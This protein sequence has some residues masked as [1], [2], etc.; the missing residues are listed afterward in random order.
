MSP[1]K[2]LILALDQGTTT[3]RALIFDTRAQILATGQNAFNQYYPQPGWVEHDAL[4]ILSSQLAAI[5]EALVVENIDPAQIR[6]IGITNQRETT[7]LWDRAT[8]VPVAPAIVWQCRRTAKMIE[9][10]TSDP[11]VY[12]RIRMSTGLV[13]DAYFSA[14]KIKWLLDTLPGVRKRA[15]RGELA[16]GTIDSWLIW[17]LTGGAVHATDYTNASRTM[18]FNIHKGCWDEWLLRLFDVP[19]QILPEVRPSAALYGYTAHPSIPAGIPL[20]G[21]AGDQQAALFGQACFLPGEAKN[22]YGTGCFMLVHTGTV[23][24]L[25]TNQLLTTMAASAPGAPAA[26]DT[27]APGAPVALD[28]A[29]SGALRSTPL[30]YA[31]EGSVFVSG[32]LIQWLRDE[33]GLIDTAAQTQLLAQSVADTA[34][35]HIVPAFTGLG[36]PYW[37]MDARGAILGLTRGATKAHI[38]RAALEAMA[39]QLSDLVEAVQADT[40]LSL[41]SLKVD[42][43][44]A[45]NDFLLQFQSDMLGLDIVRPQSSETTALGAA[46]LAGLTA[47]V[48]RSK[49]EL[50]AL[51]ASKEHRTFSPQMSPEQQQ[52]HLDG[53]HKAIARVLS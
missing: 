22:T 16:F 53:W 40:A 7:V 38:V 11:V 17:Q 51:V 18:L 3:S 5:T 47:G 9:E 10:L 35:V 32:A 52:V 43:G 1:S 6:C 41:K 12:E 21:V 14:S 25:S 24:P 28:A 29:A 8:G 13:P 30:E 49:E 26:L 33:L 23:A 34:G 20:C 42:G 4:E 46:F 31:L 48:W 27:L 44:A 39:F 2:D 37:D 50:R 19:A 36:A 15:E 45:T